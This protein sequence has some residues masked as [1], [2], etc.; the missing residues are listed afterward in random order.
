MH[1]DYVGLEVVADR[2]YDLYFCVYQIGRYDLQRNKIQD[3]LSKV[4]LSVKR[5]DLVSRV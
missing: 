4:G 5:V 2:V 3:I 1:E